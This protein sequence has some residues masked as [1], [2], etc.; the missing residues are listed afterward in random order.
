[1]WSG[2]RLGFKYSYFRSTAHRERETLKLI[3]IIT[4]GLIA[5]MLVF[6]FVPAQAD[7]DDT[8]IP[9]RVSSSYWIENPNLSVEFWQGNDWGKLNSTHTELTPRDNEC[10]GHQ[11]GFYLRD[12]HDGR[13]DFRYIYDNNGCDPGGGFGTINPNSWDTVKLC[14]YVGDGTSYCTSNYY[15]PWG[16]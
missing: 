14:E 12:D 16:N 13:Y 3:R 15:L 11:V 5:L 9:Y 8:D 7:D 1:V 10:D 4:A 2:N 6:A